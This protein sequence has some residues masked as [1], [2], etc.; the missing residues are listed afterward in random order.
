MFSIERIQWGG[1]EEQKLSKKRHFLI[2][3]TSVKEVIL[4]EKVYIAIRIDEE[5][6]AG[7][8]LIAPVCLSNTLGVDLTMDINHLMY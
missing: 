7:T 2:L 1:N 3:R 4:E 5:E 6:L 8:S